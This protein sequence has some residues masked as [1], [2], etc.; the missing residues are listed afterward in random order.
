[1]Y[2]LNQDLSYL[3]RKD[4]SDCSLGDSNQM[5]EQTEFSASEKIS[6]NG[7]TQK[8]AR[9]ICFPF[10]VGDDKLKGRY[11]YVCISSTCFRYIQIIRY[12]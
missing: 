8:M 9:N 5:D 1:M 6:L 3:D 12:K 7:D 10:R 4:A 2:I 11:D